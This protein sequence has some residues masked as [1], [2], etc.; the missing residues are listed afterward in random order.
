MTTEQTTTTDPEGQGTEGSDGQQQQQ[1]QGQESRRDRAAREETEAKDARI[2]ELEKKD[3]MRDAGIDLTT[4]IGQLFL[5][6]YK[7]ELTVEDVKAA[8]TATGIIKPEGQEGTEPPPADDGST[9]DRRQAAAGTTAEG[10]GPS[11]DP[12]A[13]AVQEGIE[14]LE[15]G[16]TMQGAMGAAFNRIAHAAM[17]EN[18]DRARF[19]PGKEDPRRGL[20]DVGPDGW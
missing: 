16:G 13:I 20:R 12:R 9:N 4:P 1:Q 3:V 2:A 18:D 8:A 15:A 10:Q 17:N 19:I 6:G 7:G 14:V 5:D 11:E